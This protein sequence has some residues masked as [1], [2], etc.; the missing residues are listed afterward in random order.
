MTWQYIMHRLTYITYTFI[1]VLSKE[2]NTDEVKG[3]SMSFKRLMVSRYPDSLLVIN[4]VHY[5]RKPN[6]LLKKDLTSWRELPYTR[7]SLQLV[8]TCMKFQQPLPR[9]AR[10]ARYMHTFPVLRPIYI[11]AEAHVTFSVASP[12]LQHKS[13]PK[14]KFLFLLGRIS[15]LTHRNQ[16]NHQSS[17]IS[18]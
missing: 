9:S 6:L 10:V 2:K 14:V 13:V 7:L 17:S 15:A 11:I 16:S 5:Q 1:H 8:I 4:S 3:W 18:Q 12:V